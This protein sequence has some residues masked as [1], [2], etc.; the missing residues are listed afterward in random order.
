MSVRAA[1]FLGVAAVIACVTVVLL[2]SGSHSAGKNGVREMGPSVLLHRGETHCQAGETVP[3]D[4]AKLRILVGTFGVPV[5][6][7]RVTAADPGGRMITRG[8]LPEGASEGRVSIP[9][10]PVSATTPGLDVCIKVLSAPGVVLYGENKSVRFDWR[11]SGS[12]SWLA[13]APTVAHRFALGKA[14]LF[15]SLWLVVAALLVLAA[16]AV[17]CRLAIRDTAARP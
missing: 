13:L 12:E 1:A 10:R 3:K 16:A 8:E 11:R 9:V 15:G 5:P 6:R 7:L 2:Q 4:A 17:A 14:S